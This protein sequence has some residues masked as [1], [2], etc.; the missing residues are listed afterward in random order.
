MREPLT[1]EEILLVLTGGEAVVLLGYQARTGCTL[2]EAQ[3]QISRDIA[4]VM[5][6]RRQ[7]KEEASDA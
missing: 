5:S 1:D 6:G 2:A 4:D 3:E 7:P